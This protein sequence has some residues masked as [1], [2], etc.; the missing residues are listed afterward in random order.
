MAAPSSALETVKSDTVMAYWR[1]L[2]FWGVAIVLSAGFVV[3]CEDQRGCKPDGPDHRAGV[4]ISPEDDICKGGVDGG[5]DD[6]GL[7]GG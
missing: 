6:G 5:G 4:G 2:V 7:G 1:I 3:A